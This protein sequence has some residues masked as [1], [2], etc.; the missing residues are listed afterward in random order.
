M[1]I[2]KKRTKFFA[3]PI[4]FTKY[5]IEDEKINVKRGFFTIVEDDAYMYKVQDVRLVRSL[6]ERIFRTGTVICYT[7]DT[8]TPEIKLI[9][10]K[11]SLEIKN[12]IMK[13]SEEARIKR[14]TMHTLD[15]NASHY[16]SDDVDDD[17]DGQ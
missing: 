6:W 5:T 17:F 16:D 9:H 12:F 3:L 1:F 13:A 11:N 10:I 14:R 4:C 2:E 15:I 8:T 7:G